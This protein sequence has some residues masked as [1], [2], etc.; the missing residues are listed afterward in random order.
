MK[1]VRQRQYRKLLAWFPAVWRR[2]WEEVVFGSL[3]DDADERGLAAVPAVEAWRL[4]GHGLIERLAAARAAVSTAALLAAVA[5]SASVFLVDPLPQV[6]AVLPALSTLVG[7]VLLT[8]ALVGL[9]YRGGLLSA[10]A[11]GFSLVLGGLALGGAFVAGQ[12]WS[13]GFD[14]ADAGRPQSG[15]ATAFL[16]LLVTAWILGATAL[17]PLLHGA[18]RSVDS[19]A[20]RGGVAVGVAV[21]AAFGVGVALISPTSCALAAAGMT[22]ATVRQQRHTLPTG[23]TAAASPGPGQRLWPRWVRLLLTGVTLTG[24]G[25]S[26]AFALTGSS[27]PGYTGDGTAAMNLG[28]GTAAVAAVPL[29]LLAGYALR[30]RPRHRHS[31]APV[32]AILAALLTAA[33]QWAGVN[34]DWQWPL[35]LAAAALIGFSI[36]LLVMPTLP[37]RGFSKGALSA[38]A[39]GTVGIPIVTIGPVTTPLIATAVLIVLL[40]R[41][42]QR[43]TA[44][45]PGSI[46]TAEV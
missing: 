17:T 12:A 27:W 5:G 16:P 3:E 41:S 43:P 15:F 24:T 39:A 38:A 36:G 20:I 7:P 2:E 44:T 22:I 4:R 23:T 6:A 34:S 33:G 42:R 32:G 45:T 31:L 46:T 14:Q 37:V 40:R 25:V 10:S 30:S 28:L 18:F 1:T 19:R 21:V 26:V 8:A 11:A 9:A 29:L 35:L 13:L